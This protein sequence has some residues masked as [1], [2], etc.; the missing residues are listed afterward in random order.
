M[1]HN[2]NDRTCELDSKINSQWEGWIRYH[3]QILTMCDAV[4]EFV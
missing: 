4:I 3:Q 2:Y 1:T